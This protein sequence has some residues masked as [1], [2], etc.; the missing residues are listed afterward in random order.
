[1]TSGPEHPIMINRHRILHRFKW[2][3]NFKLSQQFQLQKHH[4]KL[5]KNATLSDLVFKVFLAA[6]A[7][8]TAFQIAENASLSDLVFKKFLISSNFRR[9]KTNSFRMQHLSS[10]ILIFYQQL[11]LIKHRCHTLR[12]HQL[13]CLISKFSQQFQLLLIKKL[14]TI[15]LF[16]VNF[17]AHT[18]HILIPCHFICL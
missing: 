15:F 8:K 16:L 17:L 5:R 14:R 12:K 3:Q 1:M 9:Y 10:F 2:S 4:F 6:P 7:S 13:A 11:Q 18:Y